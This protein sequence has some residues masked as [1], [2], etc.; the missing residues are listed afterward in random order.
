MTR[1]FLKLGVLARLQSKR[2]F[3]PPP[4]DS[5]LETQLHDSVKILFTGMEAT[6]TANGAEV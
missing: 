5:A 1:A 6:S 3:K 4:M 2:N